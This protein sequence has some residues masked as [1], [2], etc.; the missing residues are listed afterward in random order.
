MII[1]KLIPLSLPQL[2]TNF[3]RILKST[4]KKKKK[5][6]EFPLDMHIGHIC[7]F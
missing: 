4:K 1:R 5:K 7:I 6:S 2:N 3:T